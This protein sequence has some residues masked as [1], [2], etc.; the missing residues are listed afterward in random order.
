MRIKHVCSWGSVTDLDTIGNY[1]TI[2]HPS[3]FFLADTYSKLGIK[4]ALKHYVD[5]INGFRTSYVQGEERD[6]WIVERRFDLGDFNNLKDFRI[7]VCGQAG[8]GKS[9]L[10]NKVFGINMVSQELLA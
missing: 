7:L 4:Q 2:I 9:T 8:V 10:I 6:P 3:V 1:G 5:D